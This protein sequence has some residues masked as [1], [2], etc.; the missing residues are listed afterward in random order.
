MTQ[1]KD[2][3]RGLT[4]AQ[5]KEVKSCTKCGS[6]VLPGSRF[7]HKHQPGAG[8]SN[9]GSGS[10][11]SAN[12]ERNAEDEKNEQKPTDFQ[13]LLEDT[14]A[15]IVLK[16]DVFEETPDVGQ[17]FAS[18]NINHYHF[19]NMEH[20]TPLEK[21][22][23]I[24]NINLLLK[25]TYKELAKKYD[26]DF[27]VETNKE[28]KSIYKLINHDGTDLTPE[29]KKEIQ[30]KLAKDMPEIFNKLSQSLTEKNGLNYRLMMVPR[31]PAAT[32]ENKEE[33]AEKV[34]D[35]LTSQYQSPTPFRD[36][37]SLKPKKPTE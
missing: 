36:L 2:D 22:E 3:L 21:Q 28:G 23:C 26:L 1:P 14:R 35:S 11:A 17:F 8:S 16:D 29:Q 25:D 12:D 4:D 20:L 7:C 13:F 10:N 30:S 9:G 18:T 33:E 15:N 37:K 34:E 27:K 32:Y 19:H 31:G 24:D 5:L 6:P